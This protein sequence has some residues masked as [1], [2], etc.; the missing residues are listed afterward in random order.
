VDEFLTYFP[1]YQSYIETLKEKIN[2]LIKYLNSIIQEKIVPVHY[3]TR[4]DFAEMATKTKYP[5]FFFIYYDGKVK[6][7]QEWIW[8]LTNDKI[9]EQLG[10]L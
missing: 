9:L 7:P 10:K 4:K 6:K 5:A 2:R 8:S 3:E 1:E